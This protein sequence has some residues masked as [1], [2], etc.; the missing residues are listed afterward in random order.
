[1][2]GVHLLLEGAN[3]VDTTSIMT[4]AFQSVSDSVMATIGA[5]LP[6]ALA[7][8]GAILAITIGVKFFKRF[9]K[10]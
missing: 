9:A 7:I 10:A 4:T 6:I 5:A 1:M 3:A 8:M 2:F